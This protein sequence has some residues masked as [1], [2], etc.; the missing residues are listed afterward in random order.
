M[1]NLVNAIV[2]AAALCALTLSLSGCPLPSE[3]AWRRQGDVLEIGYGNERA[4]WPQMAALHADTSALRMNYG[5]GSGWGPTVYL[6]PSLWTEEGGGARYHLGA[7]VTTRLYVDAG[8]LVLEADGVIGGLAFAATARFHPPEP[9]RFEAD[10]HVRAEGQVT[11]ADR[12][13][14][15]FQPV[16]A[17]TMHISDG[18]WD[19]QAVRIGGLCHALPL[20]GWVLAPPGETGDSFALVGGT[21]DWKPSAPTV[22]ISLDRAL[23]LQGWV[24]Q[25]ADPNDD[26]VGFWAASDSLLTEWR[27]RV[28]ATR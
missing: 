23:P 17:A 12:P 10:V 24:A 14:E 8:D 26:N 13:G 25:S 6:A 9:E 18:F 2:L 22:M 7:P 1:K 4:G 5:P 3:W 19:S 27:Y 15:A 11:L 21:S 20:D 16:H 28:T